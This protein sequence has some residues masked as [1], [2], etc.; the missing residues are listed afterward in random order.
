MKKCK[1]EWTRRDFIRGVA[2]A[3]VWGA[4]APP[5]FSQVGAVDVKK[6]VEGKEA[7]SEA[8]APE[9]ARVVLVRDR[10]V[11]EEG[12][13][14]NAEV[15]S[16]MLDDGVTTLLEEP[17]PKAAWS[18]L[19][20]P[21]DTVGIKSNE[22]SFLPTPRELE[23]AIRARVLGAG[24]TP[25][26]VSIGDRGVLKDPVFRKT[27]A[28]INVRPLR[29]HHWSGVG[30]LIKNYV[31]F[32]ASPW[33]WHDD[34]CADLAGLWDLPEVRGK[35]RLNIL[36]MLTPLFHGKGAHHYQAEYTWEYGGLIFGTDPVAV[37]ATG[38][39][40]MEAK[41][42][43]YFGKDEPFAVSPGHIR[44]AEEKYHLGVA[45]PDRIE[46][47]KIGWMEDVLI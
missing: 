32:T 1:K 16:R 37:D 33:E 45:D 28:L 42:K 25:D 4:V 20:K 26:R 22:W 23:E 46:I 14:V 3:A 36:V 6:V 19:I 13:K 40:I 47:K 21:G 29:T 38:V 27:T 35:T 34:S 24:V 17:D 10:K 9:T 39:R 7:A 2:G 43:A 11:L 8:A 31:M 44:V 41:R 15:L 18:G 5:V 12:R 30:S